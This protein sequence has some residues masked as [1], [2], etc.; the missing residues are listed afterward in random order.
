MALMMPPG[1]EVDGVNDAEV[2]EQALN[3]INSCDTLDDL[4]A[5]ADQI[6]SSR[7]ER[8]RFGS[9]CVG[10][11]AGRPLWLTVDC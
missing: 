11:S 9:Y 3:L 8:P 2:R 1:S 6:K 4:I 10:C 7:R 5:V